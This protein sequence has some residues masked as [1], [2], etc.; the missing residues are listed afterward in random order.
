MDPLP[1]PAGTID[2]P[3]AICQGVSDIVYDVPEIE[4]ATSYEW[5]LPAGVTGNSST[6]SITV[7]FGLTSVSGDITV[8]GLN[9]CGEGIESSLRVVVNPLPSPISGKT[10]LGAGESTT[11]TSSPAGGTWTS[12]NTAVATV[13]L[14]TGILTGVSQGITLV[15]YTLPSGC[16]VSETFNVL[17]G[18]W[19]ADPQDYIYN[20]RVIA[21]VTIEGTPVQSGFLAAF[22][23]DECRGIA[24]PVYYG[25]S[26]HY[27][28]NLTCY[29][30]NTEGDVLVFKYYD[31]V[32]NKEYNMDRSVD[33]V[34]GMTAG[35]EPDPLLMNV[36]V[37]YSVSFPVGWKWFSVNTTL[38]NMSLEFILS[39]VNT[40]GD[41]IKNQVESAN[42]I[43]GVGWFGTLKEIRPTELYKIK[44]QNSNMS[45]F[46]GKAVDLDTTTIELSSGWNW[47]GY[48]PQ[49][50]SPINDALS[51][52]SLVDLD[53]IKSQSNSASYITGFGWFGNLDF[54]DPSE[55]YMLRL[56]N[57]GILRYPVP[58]K[59]GAYDLADKGEY[60][61][62]LKFNFRQYEFNGTVWAQVFLD[63][64][65]AGSDIDTLY[66]YVGD[67]IRGTASGLYLSVTDK[68]LYNIMV[69]S[70]LAQGEVM[71]FGFY[72]S[73]NDKYLECDE[74]VEFI[75][76]M[77]IGEPLDPF[78]INAHSNQVNVEH[79]Y[80]NESFMHV[81]PN[82]FENNLNIEYE[83]EKPANVRLTV[84]DIYNRMINV[85][86]D[87]H[88]E[89]GNYLIR[90]DS[91][92]PPSGIYYIRLQI[93]T[94]TAIKKVILMQ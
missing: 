6:N 16:A 29:S 32:S 20:G 9:S 45:K 30:D 41:Y 8:K 28:F 13:N 50:V 85:L 92:L 22:V 37:D 3:S 17:P 49:E 4:H 33:F 46:T 62:S 35:T 89:A 44:V 31:P 90:W 14:S 1:G 19:T 94:K 18:D 91:N 43:P 5:T 59:K 58:D 12:S 26:D 78:E 38:D 48:M 2:G 52:L 56:T 15:T 83:L 88:Q 67:E 74:T 79:I 87:Q 65:P 39:S 51:S 82:P 27:I 10:Y 69:Y 7:S 75:P 60:P 55:G 47:I 72:D 68:W 81:Y 57:P 66:A 24:Q 61:D 63:D 23:N 71:N 70:D 42:Y 84:H 34:P 21:G 40:S 53:Y 93:D 54:L 86:T 36:G 77:V 76:E 80:L 25:P 73:V 11:L 64:V